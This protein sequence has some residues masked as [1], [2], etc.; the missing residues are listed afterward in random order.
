MNDRTVDGKNAVLIIDTPNISIIYNNAFG[1]IIEGHSK[2]VDFTFDDVLDIEFKKPGIS[3]NGFILFLLK[4]DDIHK[5]VLTKLDE[6]SFEITDEMVKQLEEK[7]HKH[8]SEPVVK[9]V[10]DIPP[11][12]FAVP[13]KDPFKNK[14]LYREI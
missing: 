6:Y 8:R 10:Y 9:P 12:V 13:K 4:N 7:L 2:R 1:A 11:Q 3:M 5:I 14:D